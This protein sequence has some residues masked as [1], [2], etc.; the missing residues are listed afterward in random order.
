MPSR[1][2]TR[3]SANV[4]RAGLGIPLN[5]ILKTIVVVAAQSLF[6]S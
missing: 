6:Q 5:E 3:A 1:L 2:P 4:P